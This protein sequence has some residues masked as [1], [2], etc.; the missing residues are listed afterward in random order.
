VRRLHRLAHDN[1]QGLVSRAIVEDA[2]WHADTHIYSVYPD[3]AEVDER[4]S[5]GIES[6][7]RDEKTQAAFWLR[8]QGM[9]WQA[10]GEAL[11]YRPKSAPV[12]AQRLLIPRKMQ[13][14]DR[15]Q[16]AARNPDVKREWRRK[17]R[18]VL[19]A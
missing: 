8:E 12:S 14:K 18:E 16:N 6:M 1:P 5:C 17:R 4:G 11:G 3:L 9:T 13:E 19:A 10:V 2:L 15:R 7:S